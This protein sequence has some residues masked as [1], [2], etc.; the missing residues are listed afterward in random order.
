MTKTTGTP[1]PAWTR[2]Y[3]DAIL[4]PPPE[5]HPSPPILERAVDREWDIETAD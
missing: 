2:H 1:S 5:I 4:Q 3:P